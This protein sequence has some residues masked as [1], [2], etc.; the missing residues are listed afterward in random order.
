VSDAES[1]A[2]CIRER[3]PRVER[4]RCEENRCRLDCMG[5]N[6]LVI[7]KG[8]ALSSCLRPRRGPQQTKAAD[9]VVFG[10]FAH[11]LILALVEMKG[12]DV[13]ASEAVEQLRNSA[14]DVRQVLS[15]C[16]VPADAVEPIPLVLARSWPRPAHAVITKKGNRVAFS[17]K[18]YSVIPGKCGVRLT[19]VAA[20]LQQ[21]SGAACHTP[22][23]TFGMMNRKRS[24][25]IHFS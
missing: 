8:E 21:R 22:L 17:G 9:F 12:K 1:L 24:S 13:D 11:R 15:T 5:I 14:E 25:V 16:G 4:R 6:H 19:D 18:R 7:L 10:E 2:A 20:R 23:S 3:F